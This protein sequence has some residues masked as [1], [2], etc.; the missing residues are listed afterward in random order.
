ME[1]LHS[2]RLTPKQ[3]VFWTTNMRV[4][5]W[6]V[7]EQKLKTAHEVVVRKKCFQTMLSPDGTVLACLDSD[8]GLSLIEVAT[9]TTIFEK[10]EFTQLG[11][12]DFFSLIIAAIA[13]DDL[14]PSEHEF[15]NM[16]FSPDAHYFVAG[17]RSLI[18]NAFGAATNVQSVIFDLTTRNSASVKGDLKEIISSGFAFVGPSKIAGNDGSNKKKSGIYTFAGRYAL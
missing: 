10:K 14:N 12:M 13:D 16:A 11:F 9:G 2:L 4:E 17:D 8:F 15:I 5:F 18:Y 3:I 1:S 6:D 7:A